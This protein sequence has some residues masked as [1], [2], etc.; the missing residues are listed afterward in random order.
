MPKKLFSSEHQPSERKHRGPGW[1]TKILDAFKELGKTEDEFVKYVISRALNPEDPQSSMLLRDVMQ[2]LEPTPKATAPLITFDFPSGGTMVEK[3][4][5][6]IK[7]TSEGEIPADIA[8]II[9]GMLKDRMAIEET[10]E[11]AERLERL[12]KMIAERGA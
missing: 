12:E 10:T 8:Q 9:S 2:R 5:A 11:L 1:R 4:D 7:A 3:V 6:I